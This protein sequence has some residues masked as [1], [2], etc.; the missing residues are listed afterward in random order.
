VLI[1]PKYASLS[2]TADAESAAHAMGLQVRIFNASHS[3]EVNTRS[4]RSREIATKRSLSAQ[5]PILSNGG[6]N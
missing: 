4:P 3:R 5:I 6:R 2:A 1:N